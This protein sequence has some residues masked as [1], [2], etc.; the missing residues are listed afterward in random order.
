IPVLVLSACYGLISFKIW[1]NLK[2]LISKAKIRTIK[3]T[4]IIV[5]AF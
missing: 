2:L 3:M 5:L 1:Q 4:F